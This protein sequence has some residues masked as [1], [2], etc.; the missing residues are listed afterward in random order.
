MNEQQDDGSNAPQ[1]ESLLQKAEDAILGEHYKVTEVRVGT[2]PIY[3]SQ[4]DPGCQTTSGDY[5]GV[6]ASYE[7]CPAPHSSDPASSSGPAH[8]PSPSDVGHTPYP[9][10]ASSGKSTEQLA[11]EF[12]K[13]VDSSIP[14][15]P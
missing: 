10:P 7:T 6:G 12:F 8:Q 15:P 9:D 13:Q 1:D 14:H 3:Q 5:R 11:D 4:P 2:T